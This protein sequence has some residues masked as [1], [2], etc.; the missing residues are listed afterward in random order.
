MRTRRT[1]LALVAALTIA[2]VV[3]ASPATAAGDGLS[4]SWGGAGDGTS[5]ADPGRPIGDTAPVTGQGS[6]IGDATAR[7]GGRIGDA[8]ARPGGRIGWHGCQTAPDDT[9]GRSL[10]SA[11]A[12]CGE[13]TVPLDHTRPT[14]PKITV[15]L[16]RTPATDP[17]RRRG[18]LFINPGGPG[19]PGMEQVLLGAYMPEV[20]ARYDLVGMDPR[21]VG[22]STP[23]DCRWDTDTPLRSAGPDRRS[24]EES[25]AF[26]RSLAAGCARAARETGSTQAESSQPEGNRS[27]NAQP[28]GSRPGSAQPEGSRPGS[29]QPE[30]SRPGSAQPSPGAETAQDRD[31]N[32]RLAHASTRETA[33]DMDA[34][35]TALGEDHISY[36][37]VSYGTYLGAVYLQMF[38]GRADRFVL[39][40][41]VDPSA[42]GLGTFPRQG[43][44]LTAA[45][46]EWAAWTARRDSTYHLGASAESVLAT[47]DGVHRESA[48]RALRVGRYQI[49]VHVLPLVLY[50]QLAD[51][52]DE[53]RAGLAADVRVLA[54][55]ARGDT[56]VPGAGLD[57]LLAGVTTGAG[58]AT[59]R[60]G[61]PILCA[62]RAP[63]R[64]PETYFRDIEAHRADEPLFGA[65]TRNVTPCTFWP[66]RQAERPTVVH[67]GVPALIVGAA[68]DPWTPYP[69][70]Q[71]M[72]RA[73]SG[74]R[75]VTVRGAFRHGVY[76]VA[77]NACVDASVSTY[78]TTGVLPATDKNC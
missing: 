54:D 78:L 67:N 8:A 40:S 75:M 49:D 43:P 58:P 56:V 52:G 37:G 27:G 57:Q 69:G 77:G 16:A 3:T 30:G 12:R 62:D 34:V 46:R 76:L 6:P 14:G 72:H 55:A 51:D 70:Q 1:T 9:L 35:R 44:A 5:V 29:A 32:N 23:L 42:T 74:S 73:L 65:L 66:V 59:D 50:A 61:T 10:D 7:P 71:A 11:G 53:A 48:R 63:S 36:F 41:A 38:P 60:A 26:A 39:D 68:G 20:A 24:F 47:V 22:R 18:V 28:E 15:A 25:V 45:L 17:A 4:P 64:Y 33:R 13:L 2:G 19:V 21:F 31:R